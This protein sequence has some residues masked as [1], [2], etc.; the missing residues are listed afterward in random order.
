MSHL[1]EILGAPATI[2]SLCKD[3]IKHYEENRQ[4]ELTGKAMIVAY[5]RP[6][7]MKIYHQILKIRPT[8]KE[9]IGVVMTSGNNDPEDWKEIIGTKSHKEELARKF[10]D[11][12]DPMKIAIL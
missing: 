1:E 12:N 10:K 3:I 9:K 4:F 5:S 6:I 7:A 2:D 11:N 8:W